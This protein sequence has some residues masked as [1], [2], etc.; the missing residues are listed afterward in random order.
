[1]NGHSNIKFTE[2]TFKRTTGTRTTVR[3]KNVR[4]TRNH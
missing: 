1:M 3:V 4:V 2:H